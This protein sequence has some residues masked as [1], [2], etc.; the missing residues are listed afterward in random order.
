MVKWFLRNAKI[1][2][3]GLLVVRQ[4]R[5][6]LP[7]AELIIVPLNVLYGLM[8]SLH[9][10][11]GHPTA[12]QLT[13]VFNRQY[14]SLNVNDCVNH[15]ILS[16]AQCQALKSFPAELHGQSSTIQATVTA[17]SFAADVIRRY[18]QKIFIMRDTLSSFT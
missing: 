10:Q 12:T 16:C 6:F 5:P 2:A 11:L 17:T 18:R 15:V 13:N 9:L 1:S 14:F 3:D 7:E 4:A 8:T